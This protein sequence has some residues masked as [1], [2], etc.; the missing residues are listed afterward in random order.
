MLQTQPDLPFDSHRSCDANFTQLGLFAASFPT[1][2]YRTL[3]LIEA[4]RVPTG[5]SGQPLVAHKT[6]RGANDRKGPRLSRLRMCLNVRCLVGIGCSNVRAKTLANGCRWPEAAFSERPLPTQNGPSRFSSAV[7]R[8]ADPCAVHA[9]SG[10]TGLRTWKS[11]DNRRIG[12]SYNSPRKSNH[13]E[14]GR[15]NHIIARRLWQG[16]PP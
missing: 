8:Q 10:R 5:P 1:S 14:S 15:S 13:H 16:T 7:I 9:V 4:R 12:F 2:H 6:R 3:G 11:Y